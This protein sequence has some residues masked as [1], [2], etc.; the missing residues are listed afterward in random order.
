[1]TINGTEIYMTRGDNESITITVDGQELLEDDIAE[2][3]VR[4]TVR[5]DKVIHKTVNPN[6]DQKSFTISLEPEDTRTLQF[7]NYIYDIQLTLAGI[8]RTVIRPSTF[9]I[10]E[11]VSYD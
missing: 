6:P 4:Q 8:V 10:G 11:E 9:T 2:L 5:S 7:G 3:T 1:M